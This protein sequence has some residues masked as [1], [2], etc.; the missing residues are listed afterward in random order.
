MESRRTAMGRGG[1]GVELSSEKKEDSW[2]WA[3]V[4]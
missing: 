4:W 3:A 2:T 1:K